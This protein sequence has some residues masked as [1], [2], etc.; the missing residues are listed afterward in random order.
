MGIPQPA[1]PLWDA[2]T[3][4]HNPWPAD[5]EGVAA[6]VAVAWRDG[7]KVLAEGAKE[8]GR[9][10]DASLIAWPDPVGVRY[11]DRVTALASDAGNLQQRLESR[12]A[13]ADYYSAELTSAKAAIV[14]KIKQSEQEYARLSHPLLGPA[15]R[16]A[17]AASIAVSLQGMITAKADALRQYPVPD[18]DPGPEPRGNYPATTDPVPDSS[19][20]LSHEEI[21]IAWEVFGD[22]LDISEVQLLDGGIVA[23][24][25]DNAVTI[26]NSIVFPQGTLTGNTDTPE[27]R[28]WLIHELTHVWQ[29]Q[30]GKNVFDLIPAAWNEDY[31]YGGAPA[32]S[33]AIDSGKTF[34][35]F[36][37][38]Q[39]ADIVAEYYYGKETGEYWRDRPGEYDPVPYDEI[40]EQVRRHE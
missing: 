27:F 22:S 23:D 20:K 29:Y 28:A 40:I 4:I 26:N 18:P 11:G 38:E 33:A 5:D 19:R 16:T 14:D 34:E 3:A 2:V 32:L 21:A 35:Q 24:W 6:D 1:G 9:A 37:T 10:G 15:L 30:H 17:F 25:D 8:T 12:A 36:G 13:H 7:G 39:Q 31:E